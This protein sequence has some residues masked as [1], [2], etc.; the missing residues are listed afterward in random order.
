MQQARRRSVAAEEARRR[1]AREIHDDLG[2]RLAAVA[3]ALKATRNRCPENDPRRADLEAASGSLAALGV[4][5]RRLSHDL[6]PAALERLGLSEALRDHC[7]EVERRS[8]VTVELELDDTLGPWPPEL[9]LG[10][11][12]V[13]QEALANVA[14][15]SQARTVRVALRPANGQARL[16]VEDDGIGFDLAQVRSDGGLGLVSITERAELLGGEAH[17]TSA[18][19]TGTLVEVRVPVPL[20]GTGL[21][22]RLRRHKGLV[23]ATLAVILALALGLLTTAVQARRA[24]DQASQAEAAARFLEELF[25]ASDPRQARGALPDARELLRRGAER[26]ETDLAEKPRLKARL[27][28]TLGSIHTELA[29][30]DQARPLLEEALALRERLYGGQHPEVANS[31]VRLGVLAHSSGLGEAEPLFRR[32]LAI[33]EARFGS[34]HPE[35]ADA[36]NKL[37]TALA[38]RGRFDE[39]EE[40]LRR[41]LALSETL[42]GGED[43]RLAKVLHNLSGIA[44]YRGDQAELERLLERALSIREKVLAPDDLDLAGSR[45]ALA[46]LRRRQGRLAEAAALL[47]RLVAITERVYGPDHPA[48]ARALLNLGL[49]RQDVGEVAAAEPLLRRAVTILEHTVEPDHPQRLRA[50]ASLAELRAAEGSSPPP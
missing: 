4:D 30:F 47:E 8:G 36:L 45:E 2:Q 32:A 39:A 31:L 5:L 26:L 28:D 17:I 46:L 6:H 41:S 37:G 27:L 34:D 23:A 11:F 25:R 22:R 3:L 38:A 20:P 42:W 43:L 16:T 18:A 7:A 12:R 9:A 29:L 10:F 49:V 44:L 40:I 21:G 35:V 15:H 33:R 24:R 19:G 13:A 1:I 48:L 50:V 14:R